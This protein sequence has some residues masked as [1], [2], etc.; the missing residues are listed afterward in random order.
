MWAFAQN[1][2]GDKVGALCPE[3][4][5]GGWL[6]VWDLT[7]NS[8]GAPWDLQLAPPPGSHSHWGQEG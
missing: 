3:R 4:G 5:G 6:K 8:Q 1:V 7:V 2:T